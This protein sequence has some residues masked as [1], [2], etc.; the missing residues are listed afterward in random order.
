MLC[1]GAGPCPRSMGL[2]QGWAD[3]HV[4]VVTKTP[5]PVTQTCRARAR[6]QSTPLLLGSGSYSFADCGTAARPCSLSSIPAQRQGVVA[7]MRSVAP[8]IMGYVLTIICLLAA[9][10]SASVVEVGETQFWQSRSGQVI[11]GQYIV[12]FNDQ[13]QSPEEGLERCAQRAAPPWGAVAAS[14]HRAP[15]RHTH[16][17]TARPAQARPS[18]PNSRNHQLIAEFDASDVSGPQSLP[19]ANIRTPRP[20]SPPPP[21]PPKPACRAPGSSST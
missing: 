21:N 18:P 11:P 5:S 17:P 9:S 14:R 20:P 13:V 12:I 4:T 15:K 19:Q 1:S 8:A 7:A 3:T 10:A 6:P 16:S 2:Q